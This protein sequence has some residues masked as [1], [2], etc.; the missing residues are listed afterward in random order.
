MTEASKRLDGR[1]KQLVTE[2]VD[3][4][5]AEPVTARGSMKKRA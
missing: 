3:V 2:I 1:E 4:A 5:F